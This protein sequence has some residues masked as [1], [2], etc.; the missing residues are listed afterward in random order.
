MNFLLPSLFVAFG[1]CETKLFRNQIDSLISSHGIERKFEQPAV[2][3]PFII[4]MK[5]LV[6][7]AEDDLPTLKALMATLPGPPRKKMST[8]GKMLRGKRKAAHWKV[9][10]Y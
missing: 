7:M 2:K 1:L 6:D 8:W 5:T 10:V 3:K 9:F 4:P